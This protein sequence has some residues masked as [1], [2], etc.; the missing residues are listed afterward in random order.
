MATP[1]IGVCMIVRDEQDNLTRCL[2]S[3]QGLV[4]DVIVVDTG[5]TDRTIEIAESF[6]ARVF[7]F[8][9]CDDFSAAR[10]ESL[11]HVET[12]WVM[13]LD[14]DDEL[15]E[16]Q[17]GALRALCA[18]EPGPAWGYWVD[19]RSPYGGDEDLEVT[20]RHWRLFRNQRGV[21]FRGR[22]H[23]EPW[24]PHTIQPE[25]IES[26]SQV[27]VTHWGYSSAI[28][29]QLQK[30][31]RNRRLLELAMADEPNTAL[32]HF[33][34]GRQLVR[35]G[36]FPGALRLMERAA[37]LWQLQGCPPWPFAHAIYS[38][39]AQAALRGGQLE[40]A[41]EVASRTPADL[42]SSELLCHAGEALWR[43]GRRDE[44]IARLERAW[45]DPAVVKLHLHDASTATWQPLLMLAGLYDQTERPAQGY[46]RAQRAIALAPEHP[47]ILIALAYLA[48]KLDKSREERLGWLR[49]LLTGARDDGF[50]AQGRALLLQLAA[51]DNDPLLMIEALSGE[52]KGITKQQ[53]ILMQAAAH[54]QLGDRQAQ[55]EA[56]SAGCESYPSNANI[57][58]ALAA[59]Q[60]ELE[61]ADLALNTL[62][63]GLDQP[64]SP[65][66]L[67]RQLALL[68]ASQGRAADAANA[69]ELATRIA[70]GERALVTA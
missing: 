62:A 32:H 23:E 69:F 39:A 53:A 51:S 16:A 18:S 12:D 54:G 44:A 63:A 66:E 47:E 31:A 42:V 37:D 25:Q 5:S 59:L 24:P 14:A 38:F 45:Q 35:E 6:G 15:V 65:A 28:D 29:V 2:Q 7:H 55:L 22:I 60:Q 3:V 41:V 58:L 56:L 17:P 64:D 36:D 46:E 33:N 9:W 13:W 26:Q 50:K 68:L 67:Y 8:E 34:L 1:T 20:V 57:R 21:Q 40:K 43:L 11:R 19:V 10:N 4:D 49:N 61:M 30:S 52:T 48:E 70:S 27:R